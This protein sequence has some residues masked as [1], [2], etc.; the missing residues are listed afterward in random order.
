MVTEA[1]EMEK[2]CD[3]NGAARVKN[4]T[5]WV[6]RDR[7]TYRVLKLTQPF[8]KSSSVTCNRYRVSNYL[9]RRRAG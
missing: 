8:K 7:Q 5:R 1:V 9:P 2:R 4:I 6:H 3:Q